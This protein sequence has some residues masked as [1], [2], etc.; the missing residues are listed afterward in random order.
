MNVRTS[1]TANEINVLVN[2]TSHFVTPFSLISFL[3]LLAPFTM[4]EV[5]PLI[6][7]HYY[8]IVFIIDMLLILT[9]YERLLNHRKILKEN[10]IFP[11]IIFCSSFY[12]SMIF[13]LQ[14]A[15]LS[16]YTL[17]NSTELYF[18]CKR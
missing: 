2:V 12:L 16:N 7:A 15:D 11:I 10:F 1:K 9:L 3:I 17:Y 18:F 14:Y 4:G 8:K 5:I 13:G 6:S